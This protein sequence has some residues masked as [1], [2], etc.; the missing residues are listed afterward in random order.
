MN[1]VYDASGTDCFACILAV[2]Q[3]SGD[4]AVW[5]SYRPFSDALG[6]NPVTILTFREMVDEIQ[7]ELTTK[8]LATSASRRMRSPAP[9]PGKG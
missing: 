8:I 6:G 5:E 7:S 3:L 2:A 4:K 9:E 1:A